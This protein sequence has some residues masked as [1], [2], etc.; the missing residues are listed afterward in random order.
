VISHPLFYLAGRVLRATGD[1][2]EAVQLSVDTG[3][4]ALAGARRSSIRAVPAFELAIPK[5]IFH[6]KDLSEEN[7]SI[8]LRVGS[9][10][11]TCVP[12]WATATASTAWCAYVGLTAI[13]FISYHSSQCRP[14][15]LPAA[16]ALSFFR[17][18]FSLH[19][20]A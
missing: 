6:S 12:W 16:L 7:P 1:V 11:D 13:I 2:H 9:L 19:T 4:A 14:L 15:A 8:V 3:G 17:L 10:K 20:P 5:A 18:G